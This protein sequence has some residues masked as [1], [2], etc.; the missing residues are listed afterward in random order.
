MI[1]RADRSLKTSE[2]NAMLDRRE[3]IKRAGLLLLG[4]A[5][6]WSRTPARETVFGHGREGPTTNS[7]CAAFSRKF[8]AT[9]GQVHAPGQ[10][11]VGY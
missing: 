7:C 2:G 9:P 4:A 8:A 11:G 5:L 10:P 6:P 3:M 1:A